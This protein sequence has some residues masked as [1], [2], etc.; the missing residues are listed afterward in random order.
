MIQS[1]HKEAFCCGQQKENIHKSKPMTKKV[2]A[3]VNEEKGLSNLNSW[4]SDWESD[5]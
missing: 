5:R 4:I 2:I 1:H 3:K